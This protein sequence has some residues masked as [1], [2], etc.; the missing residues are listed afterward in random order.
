MG[1][2]MTTTTLRRISL[3]VILIALATL[4][5]VAGMDWQTSDTNVDVGAT[6]IEYGLIAA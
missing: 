3:L 5:A 6:A 4:A 2:A 1:G